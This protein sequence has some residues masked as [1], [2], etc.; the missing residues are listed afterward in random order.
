MRASHPTLSNIEVR[1]AQHC[2][3]CYIFRVVKRAR[4]ARMAKLH[5]IDLA[6]SFSSTAIHLIGRCKRAVCAFFQKVNRC[7]IEFSHGSALKLGSCKAH[8]KATQRVLPNQN[9]F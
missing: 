8:R 3:L 1:I 6:H 5:S 2:N 7:A 9:T 4:A